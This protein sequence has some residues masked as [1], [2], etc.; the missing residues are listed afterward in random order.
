MD[1][2]KILH[3]NSWEECFSEGVKNDAVEALEKGKILFFPQLPFNLHPEETHLLSPLFSDGKAKNI[4]YDKKKNKLQGTKCLPKDQLLLQQMMQRFTKQT[5]SL[6]H[7]LLPAYTSS[8]QVGR[9]SYRPIEIQGRSA[10]S[11]KKDDTRLHVDAFPST[12]NQGRRILRVFSNIN[13]HGQAR[14]WRIGEDFLKVV[15]QFL[16]QVSKP[17]IGSSWLMKKIGLTKGNR[18]PYDHIMLQIHDRMKKDL[19]YQ[20]H[21]TQYEMHFPAL[22]TWIVLTDVVSHAAMV[23]QYLLEQTFYLPVHAMVD[24]T[25]SPLRVLEKFAQRELVIA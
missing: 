10:P 15:Q 22:S 14:V 19:N 11:Y 16:P 1:T 23:G 25:L 18:T 3:E 4:S 20:K 7:G 21:A 6:V 2:I 9:T 17:M 8:L 13:P 12:P 5:I 24:E